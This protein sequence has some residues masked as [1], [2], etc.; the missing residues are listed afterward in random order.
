MSS[1]SKKI[2]L[3]SVL[4]LFLAVNSIFIFGDAN[5]F[6]FVEKTIATEQSQERGITMTQ[7]KSL[8][9]A[10]VGGGLATEIEEKL[11]NGKEYYE[12]EVEYNGM[13]TEVRI[14][15]NNGDIFSIKQEEIEL[16]DEEEVTQADLAAT[17]DVLTQDQAKA[18]VLDLFAGARIIGV[19]SERENGVLIHE[20]EIHY[21][22]N[23]ID[24]EIDAKTGDVIE[25]DED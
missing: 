8:A 22:G 25:V 13:E 7:A 16:E 21:D 12:V 11:S 14:S 17:K 19:E 4:L 2:I 9:L 20:V 15:K 6:P 24:V 5:K 3:A 10:A 1:L 23:S 18:I